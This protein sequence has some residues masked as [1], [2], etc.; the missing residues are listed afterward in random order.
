MRAAA[1]LEHLG[2]SAGG[3]DDPEARRRSELVGPNV[4]RV[5]KP[6]SA[7][8]ILGAQLRGVIVLLL[9]AAAA[10]AVLSGDA[11][12][13]AAIGAVLA[14]NVALGFATELR[15]RRAM[16]ALLRL[17]VSRAVVVRGGRRLDV[18]AAA[19]V[20]G[21]VVELEAGQHVP[22]DARLLSASGLRVNEAA[23]TGESAP[24][25]KMPDAPVAEDAPL[26]DRAT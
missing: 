6:R 23:L 10:V 9:L 24:S 14:I 20:P 15:A 7:W 4:L 12:D 11:L 16:D 3:L 26:P 19:L 5:A 8:A 13:A 18:D 25:G 21:D 22:A 17:D 1:V 2:A